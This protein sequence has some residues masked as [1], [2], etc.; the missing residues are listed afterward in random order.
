MGRLIHPREDWEIT[1]PE[2]AGFDVEAW[3]RFVSDCAPT[4]ASNYRRP[5]QA[6]FGAALSCDGRL[7]HT[8]GDPDR[9]FDTAS[10]GK[11]LI[12][13]CLQLAVDRGLVRSIDD[14]IRLYW[15]GAGELAPDKRLDRGHHTGLTFAHLHDMTGGFPVSNGASWARGEDVPSWAHWSGDPA[16]D[17]RAHVPP[18][19]VRRYSSGGRWRL[20][21]ALTAIWGEDLADVLDR[22]LMVHL[23]IPRRRWDLRAG[24]EL[25][26]DPTYYRD[27]PGYGRFCDPPYEI[28]GSVVRGGGGWLVMSPKDLARLG[29]LVATLGVWDGRRCLGSSRLVTGWGGANGSQFGGTAGSTVLSWGAVTIAGLGGKPAAPLDDA[30]IQSMVRVG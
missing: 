5:G 28:D 20:A 7:V 25:A 9:A 23:G 4:E 10:A 18:G 24:R 15:T 3:Q 6:G 22:E 1:T 12:S 29:L 2:A 17:N 27:H 11:P 8:W 16:R 14:P 30:R 13:F 19:L 26:E 21:Q